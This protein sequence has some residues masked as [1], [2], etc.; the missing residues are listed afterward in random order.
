MTFDREKALNTVLYISRKLEKA[1]FHKVFKIL[2]FAEQ[3]HLAKYGSS[4]LSDVFVAMKNGPVPSKIYDILQALRNELAFEVDT[5]FE[6]KLIEV[7]DKYF[8][9]P[10]GE[11]DL[12]LLS[13]TEL[14]CLN[15]SI[16]EN[17]G[18]SYGSLTD[19]SHDDAWKKADQN[20]T[21]SIFDIA[22]TG[23]ANDQMLH[24]IKEVLE[25]QRPLHASVR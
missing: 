17:K 7:K 5:Q 25:N 19:K 12:E 8:I 9:Q 22:Q 13:E 6:K 20:D 21:M 11:F 16:Q 1:D 23:G 24:Y 4:I 18:L 14:E 2:Y 10:V 15:E 3:K